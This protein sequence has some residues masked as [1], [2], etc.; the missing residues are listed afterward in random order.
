SLENPRVPDVD[1][2]RRGERGG[3]ESRAREL[4]GEH[5]QLVDSRSELGGP[6]RRVGPL[7]R[8]GVDTVHRS[9]EDPV[10]L[11]A[12]GG[13]PLPGSAGAGGEAHVDSH[14]A[15]RREDELLAVALD[16]FLEDPAPRTSGD[17]PVSEATEGLPGADRVIPVDGL[18]TG[19]G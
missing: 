12:E 11:N 14:Q 3:L 16:V 5:G 2:G 18:L 6:R 17:V 13:P 9:A 1:L 7:C 19:D 8:L 15:V 4:P 10:D